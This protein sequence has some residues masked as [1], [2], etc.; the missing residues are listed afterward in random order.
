MCINNKSGSPGHHLCAA[1]EAHD[2]ASTRVIGVGCDWIG[3]CHVGHLVPALKTVLILRHHEL[4]K[5]LE[6]RYIHIH[7]WMDK[8]RIV[9]LERKL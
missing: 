3:P 6:P 1:S 8:G 4:E 7:R 5:K 2:L 9:R